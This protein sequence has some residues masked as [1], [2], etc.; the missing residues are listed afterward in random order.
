MK[1]FDN[2]KAH[3]PVYIGGVLVILNALIDAGD[4]SLPAHLVSVVNA[5]LT[6]AGLGVLHVRQQKS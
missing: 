2:V 3:L 4:L 5:V 1:V 6:L